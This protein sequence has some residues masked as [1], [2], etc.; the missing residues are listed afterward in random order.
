MFLKQR[1]RFTQ[2]VF[3]KAHGHVLCGVV[4]QCQS[5]EMIAFSPAT[6]VSC[7]Q[8]L[9]AKQG[10]QKEPGANGT[11]KRQVVTNFQEYDCPHEKPRSMAAGAQRQD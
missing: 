6:A 9:W 5:T 2:I 11:R 7:G 1:P 8:I 3:I 4:S 10:P